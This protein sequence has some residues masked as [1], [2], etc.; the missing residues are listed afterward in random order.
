LRGNLAYGGGPHEWLAGTP[1]ERLAKSGSPLIRN[2]AGR[3]AQ[4][5]PLAAHAK[6]I[7]SWAG[8]VECTPD[9]RPI[10]DHVPGIENAVVI[11]MSSVGFGL[12]P[13]T[14]RAVME[15]LRDGHCGF[16]DIG[17]FSLSR[18]AG[19]G[20]DWREERGWTATAHAAAP[21]SAAFPEG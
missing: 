7:R 11:T 19:L 5:L 8:F 2:I 18:F 21:R 1:T 6:V 15:L 3:I 12:S 14:G 16:A 20:P 13:A 10:I 9:G 17:M 4:M